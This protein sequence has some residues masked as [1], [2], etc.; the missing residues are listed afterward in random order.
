MFEERFEVDLSGDFSG[1][2]KSRCRSKESRLAATSL[3]CLLA[4]GCLLGQEDS[5]DVW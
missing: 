5:L 2:Q 4:A 1:P 3:L